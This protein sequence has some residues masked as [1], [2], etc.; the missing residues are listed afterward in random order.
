MSPGHGRDDLMIPDVAWALQE[1]DAKGSDS[2]T[3]DGH[4]IVAPLGGGNYGQG[5]ADEGVANMVLAQPLRSNPHNNSDPGMEARMHI[6]QG[7]SVRRL[8]PTEC[9]RLQGFPDGWTAGQADSVRYRQLGN[10]V[11]V[12]V[13][14]WIGR[15][16]AAEETR[17][18]GGQL[19]T[20]TEF[21]VLLGT[22][23]EE[24]GGGGDYWGG[25]NMTLPFAGHPTGARKA[26]AAKSAEDQ[27]ESAYRFLLADLMPFGRNAR[28]QLEHGGVDESTEHYQTVTYWYGL[29]GRSL[30]QTDELRS[31]TRPARNAHQYVSPDASAPYEH[32]FALRMAA[33]TAFAARKSIRPKPITGR[34]TTG[35]SEFTLKIDPANFGV[36]LRRKLDYTFPNQRAEVFRRGRAARS[37]RV[38]AGGHLVSGRVEHLRLLQ[39]ARRSL[40]PTQHIVQTSNRRFRD[41]EFL[42]PLE[43]TK[44][45]S[46]IRVRVKFTPVHIPLYPGH[47]E[48]ELAWS[49]IRYDVYSFVMPDFPGGTKGKGKK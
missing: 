31:A 7:T 47:P 35:T 17:A 12:P 46:A 5:N 49:E 15:R 10:A 24:W 11:A 39:P 38:E 18:N 30:V 3:K 28:I 2:S 4:L 1:R 16:L 40:A 8:T 27:I 48:A 36:M 29:P 13:S 32:H 6:Q 33:W 37:K 20:P 43:L 42:L 22:G 14:A 19:L 21:I 26:K 41:D 44:G 25:R 45:R 23:T 34:T 9:E